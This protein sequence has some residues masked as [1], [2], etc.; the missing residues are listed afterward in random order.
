MDVCVDMC[1]GSTNARAILIFT[2]KY[3]RTD[4][5]HEILRSSKYLSGQKLFLHYWYSKIYS[6]DP[7]KSGCPERNSSFPK[8]YIFLSITRF[9]FFFF[10][11][12]SLYQYFIIFY[13]YKLYNFIILYVYAWLLI[14]VCII[15][16]YFVSFCNI[17]CHTMYIPA[18]IWYCI[19][20]LYVVIVDVWS[21]KLWVC[22][23]CVCWLFSSYM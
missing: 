2:I 11:L 18:Y 16:F 5:L 15:L 10:S 12:W 9:F 6:N 13:L 14:F 19:H 7:S 3:A 22:L 21:S 17:T 1:N 20:W 23:H 4:I 8:I